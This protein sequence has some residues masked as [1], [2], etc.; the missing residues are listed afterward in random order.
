MKS[1]KIFFLSLF[2]I[3]SIFSSVL[4]NPA[5]DINVIFEEID[6]NDLEIYNLLPSLISSIK[7]LKKVYLKKKNI[8]LKIKSDAI[9]KLDHF[10]KKFLYIQSDSTFKKQLKNTLLNLKSEEETES[11]D[12]IKDMYVF[13]KK[14]LIE[15]KNEFENCE[16]YINEF[17]LK[18]TINEIFYEIKFIV[19]RNFELLKLINRK[20]QVSD[21]YF[22]DLS[23]K[24][25]NSTMLLGNKIKPVLEKSIKK[26]EIIFESREKRIKDKKQQISKNEDELL[27]CLNSIKKI[28]EK[29]NEIKN[30]LK[31]ASIKKN[32]VVYTTCN[33]DVLTNKNK[34]P[35][36]EKIIIKYDNIIDINSNVN[37]LNDENQIIEDEKYEE[38][39]WLQFENKKN[40]KHTDLES[41][42]LQKNEQSN[43]EISVIDQMLSKFLTK[44]KIHQDNLLERILSP[45]KNK[46]KELNWESQVKPLIEE[47]GGCVEKSSR[48]FLVKL[49]NIKTFF[50]THGKI[51]KDTINDHLKN[52]LIS[53]LS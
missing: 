6:E 38:K 52:F 28:Q 10:W 36:D 41:V 2:L 35:E 49:N 7:H 13:H 43:E 23:N 21:E 26:N 24:N 46:I 20:I 1:L 34:K 33:T 31:N 22:F 5:I 25:I 8:N 37:N 47:L 53:A 17:N 9:S 48:G 14:Y 39:W 30:I 11:I 19:D 4:A 51:Y 40:K 27:N 29:E 18:H 15:L 32:N 3:K 42:Y 12:F 16:N 45:G 44:A 50:H